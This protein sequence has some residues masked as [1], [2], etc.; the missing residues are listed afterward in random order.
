LG[1]L[2]RGEGYS[3]EHMEN[4]L[5]DNSLV[6]SNG[7]LLERMG[8]AEK[9][10]DGS[11]YLKENAKIEMALP[12]G[13]QLK[14]PVDQSVLDQRERSMRAKAVEGAAT[15]I[16]AKVE[17]KKAYKVKPRKPVDY[18]KIID[19]YLIAIS[20]RRAERAVAI[21]TTARD[22]LS[23]EIASLQGKIR[24][25]ISMSTS[26]FKAGNPPETPEAVKTPE[27]AFASVADPNTAFAN[28]A[29]KNPARAK[30]VLDLAHNIMVY[31]LGTQRK[32]VI[33]QL[34]RML[35]TQHSNQSA[36]S[37]IKSLGY[38]ELPETV[39]AEADPGFLESISRY[40]EL[41]TNSESEGAV[42][43][44]DDFGLHNKV[45]NGSVEVDYND[46]GEIPMW[47]HVS[48]YIE[49]NQTMLV[50]TVDADGTGKF[51]I[52]PVVSEASANGGRT[53]R[54]S[55]EVIDN[56]GMSF[57]D[58][59]ETLTSMGLDKYVETYTEIPVPP[60]LPES[61]G[62]VEKQA[63]MAAYSAELAEYVK[64]NNLSAFDTQLAQ[65]RYTLGM[66]RDYFIAD[67]RLHDVPEASLFDGAISSM[68][69][70]EVS[71]LIS[72]DPRVDLSR[73]L[74]AIIVDENGRVMP[75]E[76]TYGAFANDAKNRIG[77]IKARTLAGMS[78][79]EKVVKKKVV[80]GAGDM[81]LQTLRD[82]NAQLYAERTAE[83][84]AGGA[85]GST[86]SAARAQQ[87]LDSAIM[88]AEAAGFNY[89]KYDEAKPF[90][91]NG[92]KTGPTNVASKFSRYG[93]GV[94]RG[95]TGAVALMALINEMKYGSSDDNEQASLEGL[96]NK[97]AQY[98]PL[99]GMVAGTEAI[100]RL[101]V[102]AKLGG[103]LT[104]LGLAGGAMLGYTALTGGDILRT[105]IGLLGGTVGGIAGGLA[106]GGAG[107]LP[108]SIAGGLFADEM[109]SKITGKNSTFDMTP[110]RRVPKNV[111]VNDNNGDARSLLE[112]EFTS[113]GG[114]G[115]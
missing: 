66:N 39:Q 114:F 93:K 2:L 26:E 88:K 64:E 67:S 92:P 111:A 71:S 102:P 15:E 41:V 80:V 91:E 18:K 32:G 74:P 65:G 84:R 81:D 52:M 17:P 82:A 94:L 83:V 77:V 3:M 73:V 40:P 69:Y 108:G 14:V 55:P 100:S 103:G 101:P 104:T 60:D 61:M 22:R 36:A 54:V 97:G 90:D 43:V 56:R 79:A 33:G 115:G 31:N 42:Y 12:P 11:Y 96:Y 47:K 29:V 50:Y 89:Q 6:K 95:T 85:G 106:T 113:K 46:D 8:I 10:D 38:I 72:Q 13:T 112:S 59:T 58:M 1:S 25:A 24:D 48:K 53:Y 20:S 37:T 28:M 57:Q 27:V 4:I 99:A 49:K 19:Q 76:D 23:L 45:F 110:T 21:D 109:Y 78:T 70:Q 75:P 30:R 98:A 63:A 34:I 51:G 5:Q 9:T 86:G 68:F 16:P 62:E 7:P 87:I 107:A 35:E 105:A 44:I